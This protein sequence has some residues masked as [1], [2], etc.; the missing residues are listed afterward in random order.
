MKKR[1]TVLK[2]LTKAEESGH[3]LLHAS[4]HH[5]S[6]RSGE[7]YKELGQARQ[8]RGVLW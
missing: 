8:K 3:V 5:L 2:G 6:R 7:G 1:V 4:N